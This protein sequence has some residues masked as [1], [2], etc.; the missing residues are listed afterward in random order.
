MQTQPN[1]ILDPT[2]PE[3]TGYLLGCTINCEGAMG[4]GIAL[5]FRQAFPA[6]FG[7]YV[8]KCRRAE[9]RPG[10]PYIWQDRGPELRFTSALP[11]PRSL[12]DAQPRA[13]HPPRGHG[14]PY[15]GNHH[16]R[17]GSSVPMIGTV[18]V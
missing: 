6:L 14:Q 8:R 7:D 3:L 16:V 17:V 1:A 18:Q 4:A 10:V 5:A 12:P 2:A 13:S 9:L 11:S 15:G